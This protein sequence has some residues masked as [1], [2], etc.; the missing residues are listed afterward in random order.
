MCRLRKHFQFCLL[1]PLFKALGRAQILINM[2]K[3]IQKQFSV[4]Q[5]K[6]TLIGLKVLFLVQG[7]NRSLLE[8]LGVNIAQVIGIVHWQVVPRLIEIFTNRVPISVLSP[9]AAMYR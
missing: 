7:L 4:G 2:V 1:T 9:L 8:N 5:S 6:T 3:A